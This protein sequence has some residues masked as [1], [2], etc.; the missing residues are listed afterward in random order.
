MVLPASDSKM[1]PSSTFQ[2]LLEV[3]GLFVGS[4]EWMSS[5]V[6]TGLLPI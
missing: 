6:R 5:D 4:E 2:S 1:E 3:D